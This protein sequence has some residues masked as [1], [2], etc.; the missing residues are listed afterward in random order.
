M[1][2]S[3]YIGFFLKEISAWQKTLGVVD[4][5]LPNVLLPHLS[6][7]ITVIVAII[8][9]TACEQVIVLW[10]EVQRTWSYLESIFIGSEDIRK[11]LPEDSDRRYI[12]FLKTLLHVGQK[13]YQADNRFDRI[14]KEF[15]GMMT[16]AKKEKNV[17]RATGV[18]ILVFTSTIKITSDFGRY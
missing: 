4:T 6:V 14:D 1:M 2:T 11:Q 17:I 5:V 12:V 9:I 15:K 16:E 10:M 18:G 8:V 13:N 7:I 3:K